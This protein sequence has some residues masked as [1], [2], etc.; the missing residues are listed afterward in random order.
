MP[1]DA[2]ARPPS[3]PDDV[4]R[5][6][7]T[8]RAGDRRPARSASPMPHESAR[9]HVTGQASISTTSRRAAASCSSSSSAARSPTRGSSSIDVAEAAQVAG[10]R[11]RLHRGRRPRRQ[12]LRPGLPGRGAAGHRRVPSRRPAD[13]PARRRDP[14]GPPRR[15]A[16]PSG[17]SSSRSRRPDDRRGDRRRPLPRPDAADRPGRRRGGA[18]AGRARPRREL[19]TGGQEHF[20]LETQAALAVPGEDRADHRPFVDAE[21]QRGPGDRGPLPRAC[22]RTRSSASAR[23][24]GAAFGGKESQAAHPAAAG[25]AGRRA[26]PAGRRGRLPA[27]PGHAGHRQAAPLSRPATRSASTTTGGS[28]RST[29]ELY[30][31]GGCAADLSLAVMERSMLHA[32]NAYFIPDVAITGTVCRTNLPPNTA[33]AASAARRGSRRSRTSSRRSP[34]TWASTRSTSAGG[35]ST[36]ARAATSPRTARS[37]RDNTLPRRARPPGRVVR[38][39][40]PP[41]RGRPRF[42]AAS[43]T[44]LEGPGARRR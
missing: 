34:R 18:G 41:R 29:L 12:P 43:R 13:R 40:T 21:P 30:S 36:A 11:G 25:G 15:P 5:P 39:P 8:G 7:P 19:R 20:Y 17:S 2:T 4:P 28:T 6:I 27:R 44:Q 23:G 42:N 31:D 38:L 24:W 1:D 16:R 22:A 3:A 14:R 32:D 33:F 35:T 26:G 10:D 37:S 9:A